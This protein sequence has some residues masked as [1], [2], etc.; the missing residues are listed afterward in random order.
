ML[1]EI[2]LWET[3]TLRPT[4][5]RRQNHKKIKV[6]FNINDFIIYLA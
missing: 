1:W 2:M 3:L 4:V 6:F 5:L